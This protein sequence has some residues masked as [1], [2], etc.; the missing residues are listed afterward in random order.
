[1]LGSLCSPKTQK[2]GSFRYVRKP[3]KVRSKEGYLGLGALELE[4]GGG[5]GGG[6]TGRGGEGCGLRQPSSERREATMPVRARQNIYLRSRFSLPA[7]RKKPITAYP[8]KKKRGDRGS[9]PRT[10][11]GQDCGNSPHPTLARKKKGGLRPRDR[12][13]SKKE[14]ST[15]ADIPSHRQRRSPLLASCSPYAVSFGKRGEKKGK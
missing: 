10:K 14:T 13:A 15:S 5:G 3:V 9:L 2:V 12:I 8:P 7:G 4:L 11:K 6:G 1:V